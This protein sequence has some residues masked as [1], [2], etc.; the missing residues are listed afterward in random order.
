MR[1]KLISLEDRIVLDAELPGAL[2]EAGAL[3]TVDNYLGEGLSPDGQLAG[4]Q[5]DVH[6]V[7]IAS[8]VDNDETRQDEVEQLKN[9]AMANG[10]HVVVYD[11]DNSSR[12]VQKTPSRACGRS[13]G[14][15]F[16]KPKP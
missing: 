3:E 13:I 5:E 10:S 14:D 2:E 8:N 16:Q 4:A 9:S 11:Y 12:R 6:L 7:L 1:F 15:N